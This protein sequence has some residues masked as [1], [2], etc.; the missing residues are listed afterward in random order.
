MT[1]TNQGS[2]KPGLLLPEDRTLILQQGVWK[3]MVF[4]SQVYE[5]IQVLEHQRMQ[6]L[7]Q[8]GR[9]CSFTQKMLVGM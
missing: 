7:E 1:V 3:R 9:F 6:V 8:E 5:R 2:C 4:N